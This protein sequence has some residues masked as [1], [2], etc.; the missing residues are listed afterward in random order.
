MQLYVGIFPFISFLDSFLL[1]YKN[2]TDFYK[3]ILNFSILLNL[4]ISSKL[5]M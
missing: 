4:F 2:A 3:S 5:F 1:V